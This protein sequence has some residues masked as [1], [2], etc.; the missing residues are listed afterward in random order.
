M[1]MIQFA[2]E[3]LG[4]KHIE[5]CGYYGCTGVDASM[6]ADD[7]GILNPWLRNLRVVFRLHH[8]EFIGIRNH[9]ERYE[10]LTEIDVQE[11]CI[12]ILEAPIVQIGHRS[13]KL[14]VHGWVVD[15]WTGRIKDLELDLDHTM[16]HLKTVYQFEDVVE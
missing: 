11:Q 8:A 6:K 7:L 14:L 10:R 5:V 3:R 4:V 1:S 2:V 13:G 15:V 16:A 12:N 9:R